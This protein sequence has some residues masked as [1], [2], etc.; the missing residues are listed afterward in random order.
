MAYI[1]KEEA[2]IM[3]EALKYV[4]PSKEGWKVGF[5][6]ANSSKA[7]VTLFKGLFPYEG[8][9]QLNAYSKYGDDKTDH[10]VIFRDIVNETLEV[11][12]EYYDNSDIQS[13]YFDVAFY[14]SVRIGDY[15]RKYTYNP[16]TELDWGKVRDRVKKFAVR[17]K[18]KEG[19]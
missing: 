16:K 10:S 13:D 5:R 17:K 9:E 6:N 12:V 4:F 15:D 1:S 14:R 7:S 11:A 2:K 3:R 19:V 18:L 8:R